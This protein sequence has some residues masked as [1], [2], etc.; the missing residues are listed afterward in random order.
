MNKE[1]Y[2]LIRGEYN[3]RKVFAQQ[4]SSLSRKYSPSI[5]Y[6]AE[7]AKRMTDYSEAEN[8]L[9]FCKNIEGFISKI[10]WKIVKFYMDKEPLSWSPPV[11]YEFK[12]YED[13]LEK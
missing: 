10:E 4:L 7:Y 12:E 2:Y 5:T 11:D 13:L 9:K 6:R 8:F 3:G 1:D